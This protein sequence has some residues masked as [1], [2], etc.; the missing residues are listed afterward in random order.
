MP[1]TTRHGT[2]PRTS[3]PPWETRNTA[4]N[5]LPLTAP[6]GSTTNT[7]S[8]RSKPAAQAGPLNPSQNL[9]ELPCQPLDRKRLLQQK[10][11]LRQ[12]PPLIPA[13][14][15]GSREPACEQYRQ[16]RPQAL[17]RLGQLNPIHPRQHHIRK[18]HVHLRMRLQQPQRRR[19]A[20][21]LQRRV[22]QL[23][24]RLHRIPPH[25]RLI[26]DH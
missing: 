25:P 15:A 16:P 21:R 5:T 13:R 2:S 12:Q 24:Q 26:L 3:S 23:P 14:P 22:P 17:R 6:S 20:L 9:R 4:R 19:P 7:G 10:S 18:Q 8:R 11:P 1:S